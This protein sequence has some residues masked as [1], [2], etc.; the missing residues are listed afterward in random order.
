MIKALKEIPSKKL[1]KMRMRL[2]PLAGKKFPVSVLHEELPA[3]SETPALYHRKTD[4]Y[5][6]VLRGEATAYLDGRSFKIRKGS[7]FHIPAGAVHSFKTGRFSIEALSVFSPPLR[8]EAPD[9]HFV[10]DKRLE[11]KL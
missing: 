9:V 10:Q 11:V 6:I 2:L 8:P 1:G 4:E 3:A 5:A 7:L